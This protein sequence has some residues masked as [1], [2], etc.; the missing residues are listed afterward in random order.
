MDYVDFFGGFEGSR[1]FA[2][3]AGIFVLF[4]VWTLVWKALALWHSARRGQKGWFIALLLINTVGILEI[5]YLFGVAKINHKTV[6]P[7]KM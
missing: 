6:E 1:F 7:L 2:G 3:F 4:I 5:I